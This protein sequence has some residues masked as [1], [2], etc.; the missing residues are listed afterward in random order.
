MPEA[1]VLIN[2]ETGSEADVLNRLK[3]VKGVIEAFLVYGVYDIVAKVRADSMD[4]LKEIMT[5]HIRR[6]N[7]VRSTLTMLIIEE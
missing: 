3:K 6:I 5:L 1:I 4:K 7:N 2:A